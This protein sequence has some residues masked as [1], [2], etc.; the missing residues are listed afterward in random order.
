MNREIGKEAY[1]LNTMAKIIMKIKK[2][3]SARSWLSLWQQKPSSDIGN[4]LKG[5]GFILRC[6]TKLGT[7]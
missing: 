1:G 4:I 2:F 6:I 7:I 3:S 5:T